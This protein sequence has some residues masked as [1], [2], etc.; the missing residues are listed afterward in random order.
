MRQEYLIKFD[1]KLM[2]SQNFDSTGMLSLIDI[3]IFNPLVSL[4]FFAAHIHFYI[5]C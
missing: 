1:F 5:V 2:P 4:Q 3:M